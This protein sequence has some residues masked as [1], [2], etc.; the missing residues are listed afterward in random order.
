MHVEWQ[1]DHG[2]L[3]DD[4][5]QD[6]ER[7]L[8][9]LAEQHEAARIRETEL[10]ASV[11]RLR[12]CSEADLER[13]AELE[14]VGLITFGRLLE[15]WMEHDRGHLADMAGLRLAVESGEAPQFRKHQAA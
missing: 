7:E 15:L 5:K 9:T 3:A 13:K 14:G 1:G 2:L 10:I 8:N 11:E 4:E 12:A 6:F